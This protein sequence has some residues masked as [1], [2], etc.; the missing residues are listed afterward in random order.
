MGKW[1]IL[2]MMLS[3]D[4]YAETLMKGRPLQCNFS[5]YAHGRARTNTLPCWDFDP[6]YKRNFAGACVFRNGSW[7]YGTLTYDGKQDKYKFVSTRVCDIGVV[8]SPPI[9]S[10]A[11]R[12]PRV[13]DPIEGRTSFVTIEKGIYTS[14]ISESPMGPDETPIMCYRSE[15]LGIAQNAV[16]CSPEP[17]DPNYCDFNTTTNKKYLGKWWVQYRGKNKTSPI[18]CLGGVRSSAGDSA[19]GAYGE[20]QTVVKVETKT[21][22]DLKGI[23]PT[24]E[25]GSDKPL[26]FEVAACNITDSNKVVRIPCLNQSDVGF[27]K[28]VDAPDSVDPRLTPPGS[29][30]SI[31]REE[32]ADIKK[33]LRMFGKVPNGVVPEMSTLQS[34]LA[35][36][37]VQLAEL[38]ADLKDEVDDLLKKIKENNNGMVPKHAG[39]SISMGTCNVAWRPGFALINGKLS[40]TADL[41]PFVEGIYV[42]HKISTE[43]EV[44]K[45]FCNSAEIVRKI[46]INAS[47]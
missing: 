22:A 13:G 7:Q 26:G 27:E 34:S 38:E 30:I 10:M 18:I 29:K 14:L 42:I 32:I 45:V 6:S 15:V 5:A 19:A 21:Q 46:N 28:W 1:I 47:K 23:L 2:A 16:A 36:K 44:R 31:L 25:V 17:N 11:I 39:Y 12:S 3:T 37:E 4:S 8:V 43:K 41:K 20:N 35:E 24:P 33:K 9:N 40:K